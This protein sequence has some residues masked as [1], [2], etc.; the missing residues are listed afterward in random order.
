[1]ARS[2]RVNKY[3]RA[4]EQPPRDVT[5]LAH[6]GSRIETRRGTEWYVRSIP[7][8]RSEKAY[9]CPECL[10]E[11]PIGTAHIVAWSAEHLFGDEAAVR[12][13]RHW[14]T[15]CWRLA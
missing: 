1:V 6:G 12:D 3:R 10:N 14:H 4:A 5:H 7:A 2:R 11:V 15:H 8:Q 13:R 9:R